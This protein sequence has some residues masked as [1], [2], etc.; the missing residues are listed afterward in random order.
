[1]TIFDESSSNLFQNNFKLQQ[2]QL[3][4][5]LDLASSKLSF[6]SPNKQSQ[7]SKVP[8]VS[9]VENKDRRL[10][11]ASPVLVKHRPDESNVVHSSVKEHRN[12]HQENFIIIKGSSLSTLLNSNS[13][14]RSPTQQIR[15]LKSHFKHIADVIRF[16]C[17]ADCVKLN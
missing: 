7:M 3:H 12:T 6:F 1:M 5:I 8:Q 13:K 15:P 16:L 4:S 17:V 2:Q 10:R 11:E 9:A 14:S